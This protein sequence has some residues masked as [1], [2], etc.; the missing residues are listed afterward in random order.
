LIPVKAWLR[1]LRT[2]GRRGARIGLLFAP[3]GHFYS[4]LNDPGEVAAR[5]D[6]IFDPDPELPGIDL[7]EDAQLALLDEFAAFYADMPFPREPGH[8]ARYHLDNVFY[9]PGD[10]VVLYAMLRRLK[11]RR[12]VEVGSG[13]SSAAMLDVADRFD[14]L[15]PGFTFVEPFADR[16]HGLLTDRDRSDRRVI[17]TAVQDAPPDIFT[18]LERGDIL[19]IDSSHVVKCGSDVAHILFEILP[20]LV[21]GVVVHFHDIHWPFQYP[22]EWIEGGRAWN[23]VY[24][25]RALLQDSRR[26]RILYWNDWMAERHPDR[27]RAAMPICLENPGGGLWLEIRKDEG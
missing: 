20:R 25:I 10:A 4:P 22:R 27:L 18:A 21:P 26:L 8:G 1:L 3:P 15:D 12:V 16:L 7:R 5:A 6:R 23:E 17:E 11:P 24:A 9:G 2:L 13:F 14:D 19:F